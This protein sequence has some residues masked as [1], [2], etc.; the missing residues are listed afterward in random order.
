MRILAILLSAGLVAGFGTAA[1]A[2]PV[3]QDEPSN[4]WVADLTAIDDDDT[5]VT[6]T[7]GRLRIADLTTTPASL[8]RP[9]PEGMLVLTGHQL[10]TPADRITVTLSGQNTGVTV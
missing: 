10:A 9:V 1:Q 5:N 8:R 7:D 6:N 3:R 4:T 2:D